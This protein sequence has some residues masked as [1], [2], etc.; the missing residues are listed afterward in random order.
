MPALVFRV[1]GS[2]RTVGGADLG[3]EAAG[4]APPP[5]GVGGGAAHGQEREHDDHHEDD[6]LPGLHA[7]MKAS[8]AS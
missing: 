1:G 3:A 7:R 6:D 4:Q 8:S 5:L 2:E